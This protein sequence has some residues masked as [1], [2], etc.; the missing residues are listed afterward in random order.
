MRRH[1]FTL[2]ALLIV[3]I[4]T[5]VL[6]ALAYPALQQYTIR[7][8]RNQAE[9]TMQQLMQQQERYYTQN[10]SY[11]AFSSSISDP[12]A[13]LFQWWSGS[14]APLSAYELEGKACDGQ[15]IADCIQLIATPGTGKVDAQFRDDDC[16]KLTLTSAGLRLSSG[17]APRCWP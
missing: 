14:T 12:E 13:G 15:T 17:P 8:R 9:A 4:V 2:I 11:I 3:L 16:G 6:T 7:A 5:G 10:N 1:G